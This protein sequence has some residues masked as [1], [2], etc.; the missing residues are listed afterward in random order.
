MNKKIWTI[1]L[2]CATVLLS[3]AK[4]KSLLNIEQDLP[5][6]QVVSIPSVNI[7]DTAITHHFPTS[8]VHYSS[9]NVPVP[10]NQ[11]QY[12]SQ[13]KTADSLITRFYMKSLSLVDSPSTATFNY[14]DSVS[15]FICK[16]AND[17][18]LIAHKYGVS[19]LNS[20]TLPLDVDTTINLKDYFLNS[21]DTFYFRFSG[22][23]N[24]LPPNSLQQISINSVMHL[25]ANP[26]N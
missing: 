14:L 4:L 15:I 26:L 17:S 3:C 1:A 16:T 8:G 25:S 21:T 10:T 24:Q 7:A 12:M 11:Q 20:G 9:A 2:L 22:H 5:Y 13:Y 18:L 6:T 19:T 23:F